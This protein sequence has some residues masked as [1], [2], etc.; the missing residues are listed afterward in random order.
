MTSGSILNHAYGQNSLLHVHLF[1]EGRGGGIHAL[2][3]AVI[4]L[5]HKDMRIVLHHN[6]VEK[7]MKLPD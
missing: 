7:N 5:E 3:I 1:I 4:T 2:L 6:T